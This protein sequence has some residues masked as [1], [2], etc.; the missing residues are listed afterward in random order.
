MPTFTSDYTTEFIE[1]WTRVLGKFSGRPNLH[2]IE[3]GIFEGRTT[4]WFLENILNHETSHITCIDPNFR[5]VFLKNI[6][7]YQNKVS[8]LRERSQL[9]LRGQ[10]FAPNSIDFIYVDGYHVA[11][12][13]LED[14]ILSFRLLKVGGVLIFDDYLW[15]TDMAGNP[16]RGPKIAIDAFLEVY[17]GHYRLLEHGRQVV[18][19]KTLDS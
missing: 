12:G 7:E 4:L 18:I 9:A 11:P 17:E 2:A 3:I 19:E 10:T 8:V 6:S 5:P 15:I 1:M 16:I 14:A 13:V